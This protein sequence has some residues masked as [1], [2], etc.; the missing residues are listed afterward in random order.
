MA[1]MVVVGGLA[2]TGA[3]VAVADEAAPPSLAAEVAG[4]G[5]VLPTVTA[6]PTANYINRVYSDLFGRRPDAAGLATWGGALR[7]GTPRRAVAD[8]ITSSDEF[9]G[10]LITYTYMYFLGR[11]PEAA[12]LQSWLGAMRSGMT[13]E[14]MQA[15]FVASD[16]YMAWAGDASGW[17][18]AMYVDILDR[19][20]SSS[21][22][23]FWI[24]QLSSGAMSPYQIAL[25][26][27]MSTELLTSQ[28]DAE[29][30][31]L[32]GRR[33]DV[34]GQATWV[35]QIQSGVRYEAVIG[36][37]IASDEYY[38]GAQKG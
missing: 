30:K 14:Q 15:G 5:A 11:R 4:K 9:R 19:R 26:F 21:E 28:I 27:L 20:P 32:L 2:V 24:G 23:T 35:G 36:S 33:L 6:D 18:R 3:G 37:I 12:G 1:T 17:V 10:G 34:S 25:G 8:S 31:Y 38:A 16:E 22:V 13:I 7:A 29:Y